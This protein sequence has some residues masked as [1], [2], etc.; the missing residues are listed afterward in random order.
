[1]ANPVP[2]EIK[3][4]KLSRMVSEKCYK[5][6]YQLEVTNLEFI[7]IMGCISDNVKFMGKKFH[8]EELGLIT[9]VIDII[10]CIFMYYMFGKIN[11]I[12]DEYLEILD[13][14]VIRM[15]DFSI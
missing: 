15:K 1:M 7:A 2:W 8:K 12:N 9:V 5:R 4:K 10:S 13:N 11:E 14:N 3:T 6:I